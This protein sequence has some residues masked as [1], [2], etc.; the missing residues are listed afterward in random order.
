MDLEAKYLGLSLRSPLVASASP[1][2]QSIDGMRELA[3]AGVGAVVMPSLFAERQEA[4]R[5]EVS[6]EL[7]TEVVAEAQTYFPGYDPEGPQAQS[8]DYLRLL[9]QASSVLD[10]PVIASLN[11]ASLGEWVQFARRME[12]SGAAAV[13]CC[14]YFVPGD[15]RMTGAEVEQ[16]HVDIAAAVADAVSIPVAVKLTPYFSSVG[17]L[18]LKLA[19]TGVAG[20][21]MFN[22]FFQS[23][24][25]TEQVALVPGV[26]LSY[27]HDATLPYTWIAALRHHLPT[28]SLAGSSGVE[29]SDDVVKYLLA[30]ADAVMTTSALLRHGPGYAATLLAGVEDWASGKGYTSL[31]DFRGLLAVPEDAEANAF[32]RANYVG[33]LEDAKVTYSQ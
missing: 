12:D 10:V 29:T 16:R 32:Q 21:V 22:R 1:L 9:E 7:S 19:D 14:I 33:G 18:A 31:A 23:E 26:E 28:L 4:E 6:A 20:L 25:D 30:G 13:E 11:G 27:S 2:S 15:V 5:D 24:I 17:N 3:D 8:V